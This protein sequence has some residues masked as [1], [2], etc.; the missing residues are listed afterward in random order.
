VACAALQAEVDE[1]QDFDHEVMSNLRLI[2]AG[3]EGSVEYTLYIAPGFSNLNSKTR[4]LG[5]CK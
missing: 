4:A 5:T 3:P 1:S 2:D